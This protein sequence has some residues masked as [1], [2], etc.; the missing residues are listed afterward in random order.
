MITGEPGNWGPP[1]NAIYRGGLLEDAVNGLIQARFLHDLTI[2]EEPFSDDLAQHPDTTS[3]S[4]VLTVLCPAVAGKPG[5]KPLA[6]TKPEVVAMA[7]RLRRRGPKRAPKVCATSLLL[8]PPPA[9]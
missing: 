9:T 8:L 7:K 3:V 2:T 1:S 5:R 4:T 6:E